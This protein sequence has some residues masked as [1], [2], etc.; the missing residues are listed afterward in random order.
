MIRLKYIIQPI[1]W[2]DMW[3]HS[4]G[5]QVNASRWDRL[6]HIHLEMRWGHLLET[7]MGALCFSL[8]VFVFC[9]C[10]CVFSTCPHDLVCVLF[11]CCNGLVLF[12]CVCVFQYLYKQTC[13]HVLYTSS[14]MILCSIGHTVL[15]CY[16]CAILLKRVL[17]YHKAPWNM[18]P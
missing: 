8:C 15:F 18:A 5:R 13:I 4:V 14:S 10:V 16:T 11:S 9:A 7:H 3:D 17:E 1:L 12:W 6:T 2:Y